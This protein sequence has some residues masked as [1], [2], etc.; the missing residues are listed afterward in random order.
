MKNKMIKW[1]SLVYTIIVIVITLEL[2]VDKWKQNVVVV[3]IVVSLKCLNFVNY[4]IFIKIT[5]IIGLNILKKLN[6]N[7]FLTY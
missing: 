7:I 4:I 5:T 2:E 1:R 3:N 6:Y